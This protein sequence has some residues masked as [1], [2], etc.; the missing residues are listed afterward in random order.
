MK[1]YER[2]GDDLC[3]Y[4]DDGSV[5][6]IKDYYK[7]EK[8]KL[9]KTHKKTIVSAI[10]LIE[11]I[12]FAFIFSTPLFQFTSTS[13]HFYSKEEQDVSRANCPIKCGWD[14]IGSFILKK[15]ENKNNKLNER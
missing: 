5:F 9:S 3:I 13:I 2:I 15:K 11:I 10:S 8:K 12:I 14:I 6:T 7:K 1:Y 4:N